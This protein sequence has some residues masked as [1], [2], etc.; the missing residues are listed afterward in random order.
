MPETVYY[1]NGWP[2]R[3]PGRVWLDGIEIHN[4]YKVYTSHP[5]YHCCC[6]I[7][8]YSDSVGEQFSEHGGSKV[9]IQWEDE[10]P[11]ISVITPVVNLEAGG[12]IQ[13]DLHDKK[14]VSVEPKR[15]RRIIL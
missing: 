12:K 14:T 7:T 6:V 2:A 9:L 10:R 11:D 15:K 13:N 5:F 4:V 8:R 1:S 3:F